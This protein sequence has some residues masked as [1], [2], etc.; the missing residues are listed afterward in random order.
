MCALITIE[1]VQGLKA[2]QYSLSR[3]VDIVD[4][5]LGVEILVQ[6]VLWALCIG[7]KA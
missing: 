7:C 4:P 1:S 2:L 3:Y 5:L 6:C